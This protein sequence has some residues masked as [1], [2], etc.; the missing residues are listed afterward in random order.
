MITCY[1]QGGLGNQL[2][3]IFT[4]ISYAIQLD[5]SFFFL[6]QDKLTNGPTIRY[7]YW[8]TFLKNLKPFL[9]DVSTLPL[10]SFINESSFHYNEVTNQIKKNSN[11]INMLVGYFQSYKYFHQYKSRIFRLI[12]LEERQDFIYNKYEDEYDYDNSISLHF[13]LG[14]YKNLTDYYTLLDENYY[15]N[16]ISYILLKKPISDQ[17]TKVIYFYE[18]KDKED[19][20]K[21]IDKIKNN[22][23]Q[24]IFQECDNNLEDYE[25]LLLMSLCKYNIIANSTFSWWAAY[26]NKRISKIVCYPSKWFGTKLLTNNTN[27]LFPPNWVKIDV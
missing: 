16:A 20:E 2:F 12:K 10:L 4:T 7:T 18:K 25:E 5:I 21:M 3:Q 17:L 13:R 22:F 1:L 6:N 14:D 8:N 26:F 9:K 15:I 27:D 24:L 11:E 19:I 23:P